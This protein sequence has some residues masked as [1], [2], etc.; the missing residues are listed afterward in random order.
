MFVGSIKTEDDSIIDDDE[1]LA[2]PK[3]DFD[4]TM[5]EEDLSS[6]NSASVGS[7]ARTYRGMSWLLGSEKEKTSPGSHSEE[8]RQ[9]AADFL[10][11]ELAKQREEVNKL[12]EENTLLRYLN[13]PLNSLIFS[14]K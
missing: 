2:I 6:R 12:K 5:S 11:R 7:T 14:D 13:Y 9:R 1:D 3:L 8:T 10:K 4:D